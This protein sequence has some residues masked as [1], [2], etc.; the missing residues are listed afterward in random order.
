M[1]TFILFRSLGHGLRTSVTKLTP[2]PESP[3]AVPLCAQEGHR[4]FW[5]LNGYEPCLVVNTIAK[6]KRVGLLGCH[7][8]VASDMYFLTVLEESCPRSRS[9]GV[10]S[11]LRAPFLG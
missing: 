1:L 9:V 6:V 8:K 3:C 7:S 11:Q 10:S 4:C 5:L 2:T